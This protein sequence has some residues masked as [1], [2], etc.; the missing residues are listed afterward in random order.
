MLTMATSYR[1]C[2][3][4]T[5]R[6]PRGDLCTRSACDCI[7][8]IARHWAVAHLAVARAKISASC[9]RCNKNCSMLMWA[10]P[11]MQIVGGALRMKVLMMSFVYNGRIFS[12]MGLNLSG[13]RSYRQRIDSL[14]VPFFL[15]R[16]RTLNNRE[17]QYQT[18][19]RS[20]VR[21]AT[22]HV[23]VYESSLNQLRKSAHVS[24]AKLSNSF[25]CRGIDIKLRR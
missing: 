12:L 22:Q 10:C 18:R 19:N 17:K 20:N 6:R 8:S 24:Y 15:L 5:Q 1:R 25:Y 21:S 2:V 7:G 23:K 9:G 14:R 11:L 13:K 4:V 3:S 16:C